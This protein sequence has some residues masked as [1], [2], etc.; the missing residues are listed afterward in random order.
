[1]TFNDKLWASLC[2][3]M[4]VQTLKW[5]YNKHI[6]KWRST[7]SQRNKL[8]IY[9]RT[10][11][12]NLSNKSSSVC[13]LACFPSVNHCCTLSG[14]WWRARFV[15]GPHT[16]LTSNH[17][18]PTHRQNTHTAAPQLTHTHR[19]IFGVKYIISHF[20]F[21]YQDLSSFRYIIDLK[22]TS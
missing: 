10:E 20:Y 17:R 21:P 7:L 8:M 12:I 5:S 3:M 4:Y 9:L 14:L 18:N 16:F 2:E 13:T 22:T 11:E 6:V 1:M 15:S 19:H